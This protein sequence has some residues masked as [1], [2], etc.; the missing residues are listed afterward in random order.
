LVRA[1]KCFSYL[2]MVFV[3]LGSVCLTAGAD[4]TKKAASAPA[5]PAAAPAKPG[6]ARLPAIQQAPEARALPMGLLPAARRMVDYRRSEPRSNHQQS[7][8]RQNDHDHGSHSPTTSNSGGRR[9]RL[10]PAIR[11]PAILAGRHAFAEVGHD[12]GCVERY[13]HS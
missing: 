6:A 9:R 5:K 10:H 7:W 3:I 12:F 13:A 4:N 11:P 1:V 2:A 8:R